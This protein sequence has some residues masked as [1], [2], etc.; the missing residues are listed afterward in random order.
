M[1]RTTSAATASPMPAAWE[2]MSA[3]CSSERR[4][5]GMRAAASAPK[6]V[7]MP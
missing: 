3:C 4:D 2:R 7:E 6:P 5:A 1:P